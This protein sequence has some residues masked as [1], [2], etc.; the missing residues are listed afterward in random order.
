MK[1]V[2]A[3][4]ALIEARQAIRL[5]RNVC[6]RRAIVGR[7]EESRWLGRLGRFVLELQRQ[8]EHSVVMSGR[9]STGVKV[10]EKA[11]GSKHMEKR[12]ESQRAKAE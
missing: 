9:P 1:Y 7:S 6:R 11:T 2:C 3:V 12:S 5:C 8:C 10:S 4:A